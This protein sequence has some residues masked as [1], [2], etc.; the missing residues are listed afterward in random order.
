MNKSKNEDEKILAIISPSLTHID[1]CI[2]NF[3]HSLLPN[4][5]RS[6]KLKQRACIYN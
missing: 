3:P 4:L 1:R 6:Y 2:Y 5:D